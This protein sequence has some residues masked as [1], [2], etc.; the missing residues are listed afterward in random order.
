MPRNSRPGTRHPS[1]CPGAQG[2]PCARRQAGARRLARSGPVAATFRGCL[3]PHGS[4]WY[5]CAR[6]MSEARRTGSSGGATSGA[7]PVRIPGRSPAGSVRP[8]PRLR[9]EQAL[10]PPCRVNQPLDWTMRWCTCAPRGTV[11]RSAWKS[12]R[13]GRFPIT[14]RTDCRVRAGPVRTFRMLQPVG[15]PLPV[16][17]TV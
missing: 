6:D 13:F 16:P 3:A 15:L 5:A 4:R 7:R 17:G 2:V 14:L 9:P 12:T 11:T 10:L 8:R 1:V